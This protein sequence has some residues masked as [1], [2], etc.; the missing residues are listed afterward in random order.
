MNKIARKKLDAFAKKNRLKADH[1]AQLAKALHNASAAQT[2]A[3]LAQSSTI[4]RSHRL[5]VR[6]TSPILDASGKP[7]E[8]ATDVASIG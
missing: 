7:Q 4:L 5:V 2:E 6:P 8:A 3:I 1:K